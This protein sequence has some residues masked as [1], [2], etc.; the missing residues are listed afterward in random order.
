MGLQ[1]KKSTA[2][3]GNVI[4]TFIALF[5]LVA[6]PM[7]GLLASKAV[8]ALS[9]TV[10]S[11][12]ELRQA[13]TD[14]KADI[15]INGN[16]GI[17]SQ[18]SINHSTTFNGGTITAQRAGT[19]G[20]DDAVVYV[21]GADTVFTANGTVFD[22]NNQ[23][24]KP[25]FSSNN[26]DTR[27]QGIKVY[28]GAQVYLNNVT[29]KNAKKS[30]LHVNGTSIAT[31]ENITTS[32]NGTLF[33]GLVASDGG[34][35]N[36][37]GKSTHTNETIH[38]RIDGSG[39]INDNNQ[40]YSTGNIRTLKSAP[41]APK[42]TAPTSTITTDSAALTWNAPPAPAGRNAAYSYIVTFNGAAH[43]A[44]ETSYPLTG[45]ANGTYAVTVQSVA[46]SGLL[47]GTAS[48]SFTV[49]IPDT[50]AP[51]IPT[52][53][54]TATPSNT[55][56]TNGSY[57]TEKDFRFNL[58]S[59][60]DT[61]R[62]QL[63][64]WNDIPGSKF[65]KSTPWNPTD[66][67]WSGHMI[68]LGVYEDSFTQ[69]EGTHS[70]SFSACDAAGNCSAYSNPFVITYDKTA[71]D[72]PQLLTPDNNSYTSNRAFTN[73]WGKVDGA[74]GYQYRT[75]NTMNGSELGSILYCDGSV[76]AS[77]G[78]NG[79]AY[80]LVPNNFLVGD[81]TVT[82]GNSNTPEGN[83]Y[84]Q[85][86]AIDAAGN[87]GPWSTIYKV[88]VDVT[89]PAVPSNLSWLDSNNQN[90]SNG[91]TNIQ[92][93]TLSWKD[94]TPSD[95]DHYV[96]K[97]WTNIPDY[98]KGQGNA[99]TTSSNG[100]IKTTPTGGSI[101]TDFANKEGTYYFCVEAVDRANNNSGCS[102]TLAITYDKT[103]PVIENPSITKDLTNEYSVILD[104]KVFDTNLK[105]YN[106]RI[107]EDNKLNQVKPGIAYTGTSNADG[108]LAT[109][110]IR[111]LADGRYWVRIWA[112]D[113]AGNRRGN[114]GDNIY[115]PFTID[116]TPPE[117]TTRSIAAS[118]NTRP[119]ITGTVKDA[120]PIKSVEVNIDDGATWN[121]ATVSGNDWSFSVPTPLSVGTHKVVARATD[122]L[123]NVS[124]HDKTT[125]TTKGYWQEFTINPIRTAGS[126]DN[127]SQ[128]TTNTATPLLN[129]ANTAAFAPITGAVTTDG[130]NTTNSD[131]GDVAAATT[132]SA[133]T[134]EDSEVL[135]AEDNKQAW[136]LVNLLLTI[137][138]VL[139]SLVALS[140]LGRKE[141]RRAAVRILSLVPAAGA[142][143]LLFAA[144]NFT[145]PMGWVNTWSWLMAA[146]AL[147]QIIILSMTRKSSDVE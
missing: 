76:A 65:K 112:E 123:D 127:R 3:G 4:I 121:K 46:K 63:K 42:I 71:P 83:Y 129:N 84:W 18:I 21:T 101:W 56:K 67:S 92:K 119:T 61:V 124:S 32:N 57:T 58:S 130:T 37:N 64:Y 72:A 23:G 85:V 5:A 125:N 116:R 49:T 126:T 90:T 55:S 14:G 31:V 105:N 117:V 43:A 144:E 103:A 74:V 139:A 54:Y 19:Y 40:Q 97:F 100:Y 48:Y 73:K 6:Q 45:L 15:T 79:A 51:N 7:Y 141:N 52:F 134:N 138:I 113:Q 147:A 30:G 114:I 22:G 47:G 107:Y 131:K 143:V 95:V 53:T 122:A 24:S 111:N 9:T 145:A 60:S 98:F 87:T 78:C 8:E 104:G 77:D 88:S 29:I 16:I 133:E 128:S 17:Q 59:D 94:A 13:L 81:T 41:L 62:Y 120:H 142:L 93:G 82:R 106:V 39:T 2:L 132:Q 68:S 33:G 136:S 25:L 135:A 115:I 80:H 137:G 69:G 75:S 12:V 35:I 27:R 140:G 11:E 91:F 44:T 102:D 28:N 34:T 99:W 26:S 86:R 96:Y 118:T 38:A 36:I 1:L 109:L 66:T 10:D 70:F 20:S 50:V 89:A 110:N 146:I 108:E